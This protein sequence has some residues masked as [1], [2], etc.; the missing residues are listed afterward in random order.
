MSKFKLISTPGAKDTMLLIPGWATDY[1]IFNN[2]NIKYN[3]LLPVEFSPFMFS[4]DLLAAMKEN[5]IK[6]ISVL[7]WSMG[8][9]IA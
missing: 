5:G 6:K 3:Y 7:G 8:G 9:F 2:L 1:R 4:E